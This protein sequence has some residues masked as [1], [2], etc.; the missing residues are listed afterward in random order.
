MEGLGALLQHQGAKAVL[1]TL[2]QVEDTGT[3]LLMEQFY[4][5]RGEKRRASK[6]QALRE[7]Q[8]ALLTAP[9]SQEAKDR[10]LKNAKLTP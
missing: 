1:A 6:A 4:K 7:A 9:L 8:Q 2:W 3:A 5:M 10:L